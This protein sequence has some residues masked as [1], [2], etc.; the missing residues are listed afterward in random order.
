MARVAVDELYKKWYKP[1]R[2]WIRNR[3]NVPP[4]WVEDIAQEVFIRL[5]KYNP[6]I[7]TNAAGYVFRTASNVAQEWLDRSH[8]R[9]EHQD[10]GDVGD[11]VLGLADSP[12]DLLEEQQDERERT[13]RVEM[14]MS[15][16]KG[17]QL[18]VLMLHMYE[19][20]TYE[21][22]AKE[23]GLTYRIVLRD[24]TTAYVF[25]RRELK[26][27]VEIYTVTKEVEHVDDRAGTKSK[28]SKRP[29]GVRYT[30]PHVGV[31]D[32]VHCSGAANEPVLGGPGDKRLSDG[33]QES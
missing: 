4:L 24:L 10:M 23:L 21:Q 32:R 14:A 30:P 9:K 7:S 17:R 27:M 8:M 19:G 25:L 26:D 2:A 28:S 18:L 31:D 6:E 11:S 12:E 16:L 1:V 22:I 29:A 33:G 15:R 20:M 13:R 3:G 5:H